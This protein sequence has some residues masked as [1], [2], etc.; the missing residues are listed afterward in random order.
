[1]CWYLDI[2]ITKQ[3]NLKHYDPSYV[4]ELS[5]EYHFE[6]EF[7]RYRIARNHCLCEVFKPDFDRSTLVRILEQI[8]MNSQ[9]KRIKAMK[10]WNE[11]PQ[12]NSI[13]KIEMTE[14]SNLLNSD[15]LEVGIWYQFMDASKFRYN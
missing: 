14:F 1:M 4:H 2:N 5:N 13:F 3:T 12:T 11:L 6:G 15:K 9:T 10:Y 8:A 7:P